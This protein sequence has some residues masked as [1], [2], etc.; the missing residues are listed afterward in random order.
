MTSTI[1]ALKNILDGRPVIDTK[2]GGPKAPYRQ[3]QDEKLMEQA[4][5]KKAEYQSL[6]RLG[7]WI[8]EFTKVDGSNSIMECTLDSRLLPQTEKSQAATRPEQPNLLHVYALDREPPGWRS[9]KVL[10]IQRI[11]AKPSDI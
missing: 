4:A 10:N 3:E 6:L 11:Y 1:D 5:Q 7:T 9:C 2:L 8:I